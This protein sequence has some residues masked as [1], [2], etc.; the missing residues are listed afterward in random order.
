MV[1]ARRRKMGCRIS[2]NSGRKKPL[3]LCHPRIPD[4]L[5]IMGMLFRKRAKGNSKEGVEF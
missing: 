4:R 1:K 5:F 2:T 3:T